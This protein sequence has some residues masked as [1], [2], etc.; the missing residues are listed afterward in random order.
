V[1]R[2]LAADLIHRADTLMYDAKGRRAEEVHRCAV[3]VE[4]GE[5]VDIKDGDVFDC[6][7][8]QRRSSRE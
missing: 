2:K 4:H 5:L 1:A 8:T 7:P 3:A 6:K